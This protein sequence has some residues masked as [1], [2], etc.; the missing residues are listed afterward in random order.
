MNIKK[1]YNKVK[2]GLTKHVVDTTAIISIYNPLFAFFETCACGMSDYTSFKARILGT[3]IAYGGL[4]SAISGG[5]KLWRKMFNITKD[6][7]ESIQQKYDAAYLAAFNLAL[8]PIFYYTAGSRS[9]KEIV[10]GTAIGTA[11]G[12][13]AGGPMGYSIDGFE[14]LIGLEESKR[15]PNII[16]RQ[17]PKIKK[18]L[19]AILVATSVGL[20]GMVYS[21]T[22]DKGA[23][24]L[25]AVTQT[26]SQE[27]KLSLDR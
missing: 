9:L 21:L 16:R 27:H 25:P 1:L 2:N 14:D 15:L 10:I 11:F 13:A 22:P 8:G 12:L 18:S 19:A 7:K 4:G 5:R 17:S 3:A 24:N 23:S 20:T 6:T 26:Q